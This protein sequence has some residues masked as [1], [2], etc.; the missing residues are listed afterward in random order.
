MEEQLD[1]RT[2]RTREAI[3]SAFVT[4]VLEKGYDEVT[5]ADIAQR[6]D[7]NRGTFYNHYLGKEELLRDIHD[8]FLQGFAEALLRP[9]EGLDRIAAKDTFPSGLMLFEHI[10]LHQQVFQALLSVDKTLGHE[11]YNV[12]R[13][14][15]RRDMHIEMEDAGPPID[16][17]IMLSYRMSATVGVFLYW[18]ETGFKYSAHYMA[19]Q[20]MLLVDTRIDS[21]TF[22]RNS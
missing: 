12:M 3:K 7:Y 16:Y 9:Y 21:V 1:R 17:E 18:A 4:L 5:I 15:M 19:E 6:A 14:S 20:L 22:I 8:E 13:E 11:V 2:R 10:E